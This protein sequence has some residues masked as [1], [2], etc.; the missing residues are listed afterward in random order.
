MRQPSAAPGLVLVVEERLLFVA[1][2][3]WQALVREA[4]KLP[5]RRLRPVGAGA[6]VAGLAPLQIFH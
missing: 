4:L 2:R 1:P 6:M 3:G 5:P